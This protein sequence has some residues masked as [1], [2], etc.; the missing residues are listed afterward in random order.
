MYSKVMII[1]ILCL[2]IRG[3]A[4][5]FDEF[6]SN[7]TVTSQKT[8]M[9]KYVGARD[10]GDLK[11]QAVLPQPVRYLDSSLFEDQESDHGVD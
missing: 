10:D 11:V 9:G 5:E 2:G 7:E 1:L 6:S 3:K 8:N 4:Q